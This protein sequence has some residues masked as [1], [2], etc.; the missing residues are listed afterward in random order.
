MAA[1]T[2]S[3]RVHPNGKWAYVPNKALDYVA[4]FLFDGVTGKLTPNTPA[5]LS[6]GADSEPRHIALTP[7]GE[8]ALIAFEGSSRI[9]S[10]RVTASGTLEEV[11]TKSLLPDGFTG[12]NTGAHVLV[13]PNGKFVYASNRGHDSI[14]VFGLGDDGK[15]T[16]LEHEPSLG[17]EPRGFDIDSTGS[18]LVVANQGTGNDGALLAFA[19]G[20]DGKLTQIGEP[21]TGLKSPNS[22]SIIT[23]AKR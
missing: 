6:T 23:R 22:V 7:S 16:L 18:L 19:I 5:T 17:K 15:L 9:G 8:F 2:H 13:H 12:S 20:V 1:E 14:A 10:Y 11:E 3:V 4:Q 21:V